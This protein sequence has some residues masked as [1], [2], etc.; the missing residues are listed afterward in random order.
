MTACKENQRFITDDGTD[1]AYLYFAFDKL[2]VTAD[3][4]RGWLG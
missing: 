2:S 4:R 1:F 3:E